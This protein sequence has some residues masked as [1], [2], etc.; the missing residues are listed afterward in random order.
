M[1]AARILSAVVLITA[2]P[3]DG[4]AGESH[5]AYDPGHPGSGTTHSPGLCVAPPGVLKSCTDSASSETQWLRIPMEVR[6]PGR[7]EPPFER[8]LSS[9]SFFIDVWLEGPNGEKEFADLKCQIGFPDRDPGKTKWLPMTPYQGGNRSSRGF[10]NE[11]RCDNGSFNGGTD[12]T[13]LQALRGA[14]P[15]SAIVVIQIP[16]GVKPPQIRHVHCRSI[17]DDNQQGIWPAGR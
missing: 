12:Q 8:S 3:A 4:W 6:A 10:D 11:T 9:L 14:W 15:V 2:I 1:N 13:Q 5:A 7:K 16:P 17:T